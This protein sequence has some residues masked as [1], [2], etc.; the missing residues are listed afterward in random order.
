MNLFGRFLELSM[1]VRD[2]GESLEWYLLLGFQECAVGDIYDYHYAVVTDGRVFIGLHSADIEEICLTFVR[3]ELS[4]HFKELQALGLDVNDVYQGDEYFHQLILHDPAGLQVRLIEA[5]T[6]SPSVEDR[7]PLTGQVRNLG[8]SARYPD[9]ARE[10]WQQG[11]LSAHDDDESIE[12]LTP[13]M[14]LRLHAG[15][16]TPQLNFLCPDKQA[17]IK[18]LMKE[19]QRYQQHGELIS[20]TSPEGLQLNVLG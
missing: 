18:L 13:G 7:A 5:R 8:I 10:F 20:L 6:F 12:L 15:A 17:L 16:S 4:L 9:E 1:P 19:E 14:T 2:I 11:G 3:P